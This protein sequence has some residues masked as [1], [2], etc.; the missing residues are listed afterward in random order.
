MEKELIK[1]ELCVTDAL[2]L[3]PYQQEAVRKAV[4]FF[5]AESPKPSLI[6]LP[7]AWGKSVLTAFVAKNASE[8]LLVLQPSRELLEQNY[9]RYVDLCEFEVQAGIYS[10]GFGRREIDR[11]TYA[12]IGSIYKHGDLFRRLGFRRML[13]D[14]A[15]LYPR[16]A[17]SMFGKFIVESGITHVLGITATPVKLQQHN[18]LRGER[19]SKL[20]MLTSR[21]RQGNF[22]R[23]IIHVAQA[24][25]MVRLGFWSRLRYLVAGFDSSMLVY[26]SV[27]SDYTEESLRRAFTAN[28][29]HAR[30]RRQL[31]QLTDRRHILVFVPSVA[32]AIDL[33]RSY[34]AAGVVYGEQP[35][36]ERART[37]DA[38]RRGALR[39][40]VNVRVLAAGFDYTGIDCIILG[41]STASVALYYQIIG[42]GTRIDPDKQDCLVVDLAGNVPRFGRVEEITFEKEARTWHMYGTGGRLLSGIPVH[43]IGKIRRNGMQLK[44][45]N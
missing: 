18:D 13:V 29:T 33:A 25:E 41:A 8:K 12:T 34:P 1:N 42:R 6:V 9:R 27:R 17:D 28:D 40:L 38:F 19:Y 23:E 2:T 30:I 45:K 10:A 35:P 37:I 14:E 16:S 31:D 36:Q 26:N 4:G 44:I 3:R 5:Q 32:E 43:E 22:F 21:S 24:S 39:V 11:I 7:T 20:V 15:H